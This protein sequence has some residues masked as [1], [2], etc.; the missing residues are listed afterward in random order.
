[1]KHIKLKKD[2]HLLI[3]ELNSAIP[4]QKAEEIATRLRDEI[5]EF[6]SLITQSEITVLSLEDESDSLAALLK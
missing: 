3:F 4:T 5:P 2:K 1:M 6:K